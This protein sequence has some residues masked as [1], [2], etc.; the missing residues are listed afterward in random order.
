M[1]CGLAI[2]WVRKNCLCDPQ[3]EVYG[4]Y[5]RIERE[6]EV[7]NLLRDCHLSL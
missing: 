2:N 5:K 4:L 7:D 6:Y 3:N 1:V